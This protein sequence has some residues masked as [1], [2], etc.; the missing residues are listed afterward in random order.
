MWLRGS[1]DVN[2][3]FSEIESAV[4]A[5]EQSGHHGLSLSDLISA[6]VLKPL[7]ISVAL[8]F[9][10]QVSGVNAVIFYTSQIF[11]SAGF[12]SNPNT[13]T[14]IVGAVLVVSTLVSCIVADLA[15]RRKLL[16]TS[17]VIMTISIAL[18][19]V[20]F[21][22]TEKRQV[23]MCLSISSVYVCCLGCVWQGGK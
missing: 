7:G 17:G 13:P 5:M 8:M 1:V 22:V 4:S 10:Q 12:S 14:M 3:E 23:C 20:Y 6:R 15:G 21:Y 9:F 2:T 16:I 18:L 11:S 19:G